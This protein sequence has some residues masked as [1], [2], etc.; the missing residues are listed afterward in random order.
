MKKLIA[1]IAI[2][3]L[4]LSGCT[5]LTDMPDR[6]TKSWQTLTIIGVGTFMIPADWYA[7][8]QDDYLFITDKPLSEDDY[9]VLIAGAFMGK[10]PYIVFEGVTRDDMLFSQ[11]FSN[12]AMLFLHE[13]NVNETKEEFSTISLTNI[14]GGNYTFFDLFVWNR[15]IAD[16][17]LVEQI[18]KTYRTDQKDYSNPNI[19]QLMTG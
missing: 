4:L 5:I 11:I 17:W 6:I 19:G 16:E 12:G 10:S 8:Q 18:A 15:D 2:S 13:Y 14:S 7:E 1:P 9:T 3:L